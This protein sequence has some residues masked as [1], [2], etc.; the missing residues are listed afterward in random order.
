MSNAATAW[1]RL[2]GSLKLYVSIAKEPYKRD[3]ILQKRPILLRSLLLVA[4]PYNDGSSAILCSDTP[5]MYGPLERCIDGP[6]T[7]SLMTLRTLS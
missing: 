1:L 4:T 3:D 5:L 2:V 6:L 7:K